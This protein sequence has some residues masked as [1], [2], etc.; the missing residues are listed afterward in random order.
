MSLISL[1]SRVFGLRARARLVAIA[2]IV[3]A[4]V[5]VLAALETWRSFN[6]LLLPT[7]I[8]LPYLE[9]LPSLSPRSLPAFTL[10]W[11]LAAVVFLLGW[12][13]RVAGALLAGVIAYTLLWDQQLYSNHLYLLFLMVL[14]LTIAD[15]GAAISFDAGRGDR[16]SIEGW[17]VLLL[18]LQVSIVYIF[19][20]VA[21]LTPEYLSGEVL[22]QS[23]KRAGYF[24]FST[25]W[26]VVNVMVTL[27]VIAIVLEL[28]IGLGLW[29][30]RL[31]LAAV[32]AGV[33]F[34]LFIIAALDSSRLSLGIFA[35]EMFAV[36][37]LF[38]DNPGN[39]ESGRAFGSKAQ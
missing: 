33:G 17:P 27:A 14:L 22:S 28:F 5:C 37:P 39:D 29:F 34:H 6:R 7:V 26:R 2:R 3:I 20:A 31:R 9:S 12:H 11:L 10:L 32:I 1:L 30:K 35:L 16:P 19:S 4:L 18:K 13:T 23:L 21:K 38:F 24:A 25:S 8:K 15:S 36:Y